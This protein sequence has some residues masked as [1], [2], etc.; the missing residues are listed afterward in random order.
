MKPD[1]V[2]KSS[3]AL[4]TGTQA[5]SVYEA[6]IELLY[7]ISRLFLTEQYTAETL[8]S[9]AQRLHKALLAAPYEKYAN[10]LCLRELIDLLKVDTRVKLVLPLNFDEVSCL[11]LRDRFGFSCFETA[12]ILGTSEGSVRTRLERARA[13]AFN[14]AHHSTLEKSAAG[15]S[16]HLCIRTREVVED[17]NV[18]TAPL[19]QFTPPQTLVRAVGDCHRCDDVLNHRLASLAYF[20]ERPIHTI[21]PDLIKFPVAPLFVKEGKKVYFN[22]GASPWYIKALFEGVLATSLVLGIVLSIPR[23]KTIYEFWLE[24]RFDLYSIAELASN[25]GSRTDASEESQTG[26]GPAHVEKP[27]NAPAEGST[28]LAANTAARP[29][30]DHK[31][32]ATSAASGSAPAQQVPVPTDSQAATTNE[33]SKPRSFSK[34]I[35][36]LFARLT[37][38]S[39]GDHDRAK[40]ADAASELK[41][42]FENSNASH[43]LGMNRVGQ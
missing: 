33:S 25:L 9:F 12:A 26:P 28:P 14:E 13:R 15:N 19:G 24:K 34:K 35:A 18:S 2:V 10:L 27:A 11:I 21:P 36:R 40:S 1:S 43:F 16:T 8:H 23:I 39:L 41:S 3:S 17:W 32:P 22:W 29:L 37:G 6:N 31:S 38:R 20:R 7:Q 5:A 4:H 42:L 30:A